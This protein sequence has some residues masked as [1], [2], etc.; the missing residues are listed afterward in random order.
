MG[1]KDGINTD[2]TP[3]IKDMDFPN[4]LQNA[5]GYLKRVIMP[6]FLYNSYFFSMSDY[7]F[8]RFVLNR[9]ED[10]SVHY[11]NKMDKDTKRPLKGKE[12]FIDNL[13]SIIGIAMFH[14]AKVLLST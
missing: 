6:R 7:L 9:C 4:R 8:D 13:R 5:V 14:N 3:Y 12:V 10:M 11:I 1:F 2:Y